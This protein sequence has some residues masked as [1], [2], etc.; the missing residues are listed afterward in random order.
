MDQQ[1]VGGDLV[2][3]GG[4]G[5]SHSRLRSFL[6][7]LSNQRV[8]V[9]M[10]FPMVVWVVIFAYLPLTGWIM[11]FQDY[12]PQFGRLD[13][14]W[15]GLEN[16]RMFLEDPRFYDVLR[17]TLVMSALHIVFGFF[18]AISLAII[19]N[20]VGSRLFKR[21]IQTI[22]Y[23]PH[24]VSWV[25]VASIFYTV[26]S[27]DNGVVN[28][29]LMAVGIIDEPIRF[30]A[31]PHL[32]WPMITL[33][34]VWKEMGWNAII[35]LAAITSID[36]QLY[37][38]ARVDGV[39]RIGQIFHITLP[40]IRP[41]IILLLV[42]AIGGLLHIQ[43]FEP[44]FLLGNSLTRSHADNLAVYAYR[45]GIGLTRY[46][47]STAISIFNSVVSITLLI[48]ANRLSARFGEGTII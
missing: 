35:Y 43:G 38:A 46:S 15:V 13:Q 36:P 7:T 47:L 21:S 24:F 6:T 1:R 29:T 26:F 41:T 23:L 20:E 11:A 9:A 48:F 22:S 16:F 32:F 42:L 34:Q 12:R 8:L 40:G 27:T 37:E 14:E 45:Y 17:N 2:H 39:G 28:N 33:A 31:Q 30:L 3:T 10:S 5:T 44:V 18:F 19:L 4:A 25:V